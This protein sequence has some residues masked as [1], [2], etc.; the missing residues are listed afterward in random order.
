MRIP[1]HIPVLADGDAVREAAALCSAKENDAAFASIYLLR[2]KYGTEIAVHCGMLLRRYQSGYR[3]GSCGYPLGESARLRET[4]C[5]LYADAQEA[6][7]Q[8]KF[9][10]LTEEQCMTLQTL[11]PDAF[12]VTAAE[13]YTEYLYL[14]DNLA[15]L[16]GSKYHGKR[17]HIAQFWRGNPEAMIQPLIAENAQYAV[18]IARAWLD[19]R[20]NPE[21]PSLLFEYRCIEEAAAHFDALGMT[22]LLLYAGG[23]PAGMAMVSEISPG[24]LDVHFEKVRPEYPHAWSVVANETA[25]CMPHAEYLNREEDLGES[26]M[27]RSKQSYKP[28]LLNLKFN[29]ALKEGV[30]LC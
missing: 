15:N 4:V 8:L 29:A 28:D 23:Q 5:A 7:V 26:G 13:E 30:S 11:F 9:T 16:R 21:E 1:F 18:E 12:T 25:K 19:H 10:L 17:N 24:I 20:E 14:R 3:A 6:G 27:R 22:G 2:E